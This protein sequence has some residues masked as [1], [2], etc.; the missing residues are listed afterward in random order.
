MYVKFRA[1]LK[2]RTLSSENHVISGFGD[3]HV[4]DVIVLI[5]AFL[6]SPRQK[7]ALHIEHVEISD[8]C[9]VSSF[10][11]RYPKFGAFATGQG[12]PHG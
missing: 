1:E 11:G 5:M 10:Q 9:V 2:R 12:V 8:H 6:P 3:L 4:S 7:S